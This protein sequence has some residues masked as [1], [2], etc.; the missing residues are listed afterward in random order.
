MDAA[1]RT[2]IDEAA[3]LRTAHLYARGADR[4][5]PEIWRGIL[6]DDCVLDGPGFLMKGLDECLGVPIMLGDMYRA[7]AH[8]IHQQIA[9]VDGDRASGETYCSAE[10]LLKDEDAIFIWSIRYQD[11]WRRV[12]GDWRFCRRD[13]EVDW[14]ETRPAKRVGAA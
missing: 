9:T 5:D 13:L 2:M 12:D 3:L 6:T 4:C 14:E 10:H 8:K 11:R 1:T 7:T